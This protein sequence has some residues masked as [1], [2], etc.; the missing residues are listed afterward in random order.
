MRSY[1]LPLFPRKP[2]LIPDQNG[3]SQ[4]FSDKN[5]AKTLPFGATHMYM[6]YI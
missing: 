1:T 3:Q 5:S 6:A 4:L 2:Y